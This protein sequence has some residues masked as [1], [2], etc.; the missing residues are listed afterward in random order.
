MASSDEEI[1]A[2]RRSV[3]SAGFTE[4]LDLS[5]ASLDTV[6]D[7]YRAALKQGADAE[8]QHQVATYWGEVLV[9][10]LGGR[11]ATDRDNMRHIIGL[12]KLKRSKALPDNT[13][14]VFARSRRPGYLRDTAELHDIAARQQ[15]LEASLA[16]RDEELA[17]LVEDVRE[18][19]G[20]A[21]AL[22]ETEAF[23]D[24]CEEATRAAL[25]QGA[26]RELLR[27][28]R[29]RVVLYF[30]D[31]V[32]RRIGGEW[33]VETTPNQR[34]LGEF[35]VGGWA[36]AGMIRRVVKASPPHRLT[37]ELERLLKRAGKS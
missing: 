19:L 34:D 37:G 5:F 16:N 4:P 12:P 27:R 24:A 21:P 33:S 2:L 35:T 14:N 25:K 23:L 7:F 30:G 26:P 15:E 29:R 8:L 9:A 10:Q 31:V 22:D 11:W 28:L 6:E 18:L 17:A 32:Q 20:A 3:A 1:G 36:P 13:A